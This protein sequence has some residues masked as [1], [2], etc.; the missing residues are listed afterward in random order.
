MSNNPRGAVALGIPAV[1]L[2]IVTVAMLVS[3]KYGV[4]C[5]GSIV[6]L[7]FLFAPPS[8]TAVT[9]AV[10][11]L[12]WAPDA[13]ALG[14][15]HGAPVS[16]RWVVVGLVFLMCASWIVRGRARPHFS[17]SRSWMLLT[18]VVIVGGILDHR[19]HGILDFFGFALVPYIVG[20]T[21]GH[22]GDRLLG[23]I[24]GLVAGACVCAAEA[25]IEFLRST[26]F[27]PAPAHAG[28][29]IRAGNLRAYAGWEHPLALGMFLCLTAFLVIDWARTKGPMMMI[30]AVI[31]MAAGVFATQER[32][33]LL[34]LAAGVATF[35]ILQPRLR[36][37]IRTL[38]VSSVAVLVV[39][40]FPGSSGAS[41]RS[42]L[43]ESTTVANKAG[44]DVTGRF[45]LL[46]L[47]LH[48]VFSRP[49]YGWGYGVNDTT[50]T[51]Q[52]L[53]SE[54][55]S[56]SHTYTDIANWPLAMAIQTGFVG[57]G[58]LMVIVLG[59]FV[60]L[61]RLRKENT[62]LPIIPAVAGLIGAFVA[63]FG[64]EARSS[65]LV[66]LFVLGAFSTG[67]ALRRSDAAT[68]EVLARSSPR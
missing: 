31:L 1:I 16:P 49:L 43:T 18:I 62:V 56:G 12:V 63:S 4:A 68:I 35:V 33:P 5:L 65:T 42:Y 34:G 8:R 55:T 58:A 44:S 21:I 50:G 25:I 14:Y 41:F 61:I 36:Y 46:K 15:V 19:I 24:H 10:F 39:L 32:S 48:A 6:L 38:A 51:V 9:G 27:F 64:V 23:V 60:R 54:L 13:P 28:S 40:L 52:G 53:A 37:K 20:C 7:L 67:C 29:F 45:T 57:F 59:N 66:F 47:G 30:G 22:E 26:P 17:F 3:V 2:G 11:L